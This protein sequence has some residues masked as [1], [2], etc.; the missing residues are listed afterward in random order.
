M[1]KKYVNY[2]KMASEEPMSEPSVIEPEA[3]LN[4]EEVKTLQEDE[5]TT[6]TAIGVV[7]GCEKL[8]VRET[9][10]SAGKIACVIE[11]GSQVCIDETASTDE[12]YKVCAKN[13]IEGFCMKKFIEVLPL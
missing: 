7:V 10:D 3:A 2:S 11:K 13:G 8:N 1:S 6:V 4:E 12:W 9:P 5:I